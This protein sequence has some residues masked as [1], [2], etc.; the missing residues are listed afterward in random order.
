MSN[1]TETGLFL[2]KKLIVFSNDI[3]TVLPELFLA[4]SILSLVIYSVNLATNSKYN[5]PLINGN[6]SYLSLLVLSLT[7][8]LVQN[9]TVISFSTFNN[10]II[11]DNLATFTKSVILL[12]TIGYL[13]IS[14]SYITNCRFNAFEYYILVLS[15]ILGLLLLI[16]SYDL[17]IAYIA[18]EMQS[19]SFYVLAAF[20]RNS[21]F[22][23][24]A[25]LKY[26]ILGAFSSSLILF[27]SSLIYGFTGTTN[28]GDLSSILIGVNSINVL[29]G[30][31]ILE[32]AIIFLGVGLLFK[33]AAAPFHMWSPDVYEGAPT[34]STA[35]FA[36]LPKIAIFVLFARLF[37]FSFYNFIESW[38]QLMIFSAL[39][40]VI[41]GSFVAL[42]QRK[43]KRLI[44]YSAIS[45]I[46]YLLIA[47]TTGTLEGCQA[48]FMYLFIYMITGLCVWAIIMSIELQTKKR[49]SFNKNLTDLSLLVHTNGLLGIT[50]VI[51]LFSLAGVPPLAGFYVKMQIFFSSINASMYILSIIGI[52]SSVISTFYYIRIIKTMYFEKSYTWNFY[53]PIGQL[54]SLVLGISLFLII[55]LFIDP[56]LLSLLTYKMATSLFI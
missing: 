36:I 51:V 34:S 43:I 28:F 10:I 17:I 41:I 27:G 6:I 54:K 37:Q 14:K 21:A 44:A 31:R 24:E 49:N 19:L 50:F 8:L 52:L 53:K 2:V 38:Q 33:L 15:A 29:S 56:N 13:L 45:H 1:Y 18:I 16:S 32:V 12:S 23:T 55:L 47:F 7:F 22:S 26:F 35:L 39:F 4:T 42:K 3:K 11:Y 25:G 20:K 46:G 40:S 9:G 48:I 5:Y 30:S